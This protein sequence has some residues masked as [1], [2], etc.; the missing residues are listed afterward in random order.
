RIFKECTDVGHECSPKCKAH[1][2]CNRDSKGCSNCGDDARRF[3]FVAVSKA[4]DPRKGFWEYVLVSD[5]ADWPL[6]SVRNG[7]LLIAN[8]GGKR[9]YVFDAKKLIDG[10]ASHSWLATYSDRDFPESTVIT[11]VTQYSDA[12]GLSLILGRGDNQLT[13]YAFKDP[14]KPL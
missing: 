5:N 11:P 3:T 7:R 14:G 6:F 8:N 13:V 12:D 9:V 1:Q 10:V 4:E 2:I